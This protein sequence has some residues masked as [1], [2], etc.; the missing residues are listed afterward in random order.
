VDPAEETKA[1]E[2]HSRG[3]MSYVGWAGVIVLLY[4]L[5]FGPVFLIIFK[6][7]FPSYYL[8]VLYQPWIWVYE[9]TPLHKP[10]GIYM[11]LWSPDYF[12]KNGDGN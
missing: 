2:K 12:D 10:L 9:E 11:H 4:F 7:S 5:S 1:E 6:T 3:F 8:D